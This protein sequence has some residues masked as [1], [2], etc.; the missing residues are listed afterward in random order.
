MHGLDSVGLAP[1]GSTLLH[2]HVVRQ[3]RLVS[4]AP[5]YITHEAHET[6][7]TRLRVADPLETLRLRVQRPRTEIVE[8][9]TWPLYSPSQYITGGNS[10][11]TISARRLSTLSSYSTTIP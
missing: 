4:K 7:L 2:K 10:W 6:L 3:L 9:V 8:R 1:G 11:R 5:S